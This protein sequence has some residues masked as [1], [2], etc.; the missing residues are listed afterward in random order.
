MADPHPSTT[1]VWT[2]LIRAGSRLVGA[3]EA[4]LRAA[5]LPPLDWYDV[6]WEIE[7]APDGVRPLVLQ[8]RLLLPQYGLSRL[9]ERMDRAG[10]LERRAC[11]ED[12]RGQVL[13]LTAEGRRVRAAMWPVYSATLVAQVENRIS[14]DEALALA[15]LLDVLAKGGSTPD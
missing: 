11:A 3:V 8:E 14:R 15:R 13:V 9:V 7:K 12:G 10:Y 6:L 4:A 2:R 5:E 1:A